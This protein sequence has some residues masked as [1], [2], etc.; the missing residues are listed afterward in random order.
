MAIKITKGTAASFDN[1]ITQII[2]WV[3]DK[4]VQGDDAWT[5][6]RNE[7][8]PRG[9]ILKAAG[10]ESGEY[11]YIGLLPNEIEKGKTY[12]DWFLQKKNLA[13]HF[14]WSPNGL[15]KPGKDFDAAKMP[16]VETPDI[17]EASAQ[18]LHLGIFKQYSAELDWQEQGGGIDFS[19]IKLLPL[20]YMQE[21]GGKVDYNPPLLPGCGYPT[22]SIDF[23][24]PTIDVFKFWLVK[25][26][27]RLIIVMNNAEVW[28]SAFLGQFEPYDGGEYAF[29]AAVV[30]G[31]SGLVSVGRNY[32]YSPNQR[33]PVPVIGMRLDY[34]PQQW[35]LTHGIAPFATA[36][37]DAAGIPTQVMLCHP[38]GTWQGYANYVQAITAVADHVCNGYV[39]NY[40]FVRQEP[41]RPQNIKFRIRPTE[42][43]IEDFA[44][45]YG[46]LKLEPI[47]LLQMDSECRGILGKLPYMFFSS[48]P[49]KEYGEITISGKKYLSIPNGWEDRKFH[50]PGHAGVVYN[51][52]VDTLLVQE[53]RIEK[54]SKMMNLLI[55][56][57]E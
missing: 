12:A 7:P 47:E 28:D 14:V 11:Q 32:W 6:M 48:R 2:T 54:I 23:T 53:R 49:M 19:N 42:N 57:E 25:D 27:Q 10:R 8:W 37:G 22:L 1:L 33:S 43:D 36:A 56:L 31:T 46:K 52:D 39:T 18:V 9:T 45:G 20:Q 17:F 3:T 16:F 40:H 50:I 5:L 13:T 30:G 15:N 4:T 51:C 38:D 44:H 24:G 41:A 34:R 55:R 21:N 29:P 26:A 35:S